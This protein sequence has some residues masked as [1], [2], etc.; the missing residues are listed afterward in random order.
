MVAS[1]IAGHPQTKTILVYDLENKS[2]DSITGVTFDTTKLSDKT[3]FY[4]GT[5]HPVI[6]ILEQVPPDSNIY[7]NSHFTYK[8]QAS[9]DYDLTKFPIRTSV[10]MISHK[11]DYSLNVCSGTIISRR[12]VLTAAHCVSHPFTD[13]L[14][15]DS[16]VVCPVFDNGN[17]SPVF[18]C[19]PIKKIYLFKHWNIMIE[20]FAILEMKEPI[21]EQTGWISIGFNAVD[22]LL[23]EGILY[24]F[25]YPAVDYYNGDTLYYNYGLVDIVTENSLVISH[26]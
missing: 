23:T 2:V 11:L 19:T 26:T 8:R 21:G 18:P 22:S 3:I 24:K 10:K 20:D 6:K 1:I 5:Y 9:L 7:P 4:I 13:T 14:N 16:L 12:H 25:S 17:P 15:L